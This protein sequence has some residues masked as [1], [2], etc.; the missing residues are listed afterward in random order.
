MNFLDLLNDKLADIFETDKYAFN[1]EAPELSPERLFAL[2]VGAINA[3]QTG[4][5][6]NSL[7]TG[8]DVD[9]LREKLEENYGITDEASFGET[10][11]WFLHQGHR[12]D[13]E[14][15]VKPLLAGQSIDFPEDMTESAKA[16]VL[17]E[18]SDY[19]AH[20]HECTEELKDVHFIAKP[21]DF[22]SADIFAW[23]FG[24]CIVVVRSAYDCGFVSEEDAWEIIEVI[25]RAAGKHYVSW[26]DLAAGYLIGRAMWA[27]SDMM[28]MGLISIA[29]GLLE[30]EDS[31]W[32][33]IPFRINEDEDDELD[34]EADNDE[35]DPS[36]R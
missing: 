3:E 4:F 22:L 21:E 12:M 7:T 26:K 19:V 16:E 31:P 30:D 24:R 20:L 29:E 9:E 35:V 17:D 5:F 11:R 28:L 27:G 2:N 10:L 33:K 14:Y 1:P 13:F 36:A 23:D 25:G 32:A 34:E 18:M 6:T 8:K 15:G